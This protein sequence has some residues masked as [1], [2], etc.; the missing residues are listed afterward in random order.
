VVSTIVRYIHSVRSTCEI[1]LSVSVSFSFHHRLS[2]YVYYCGILVVLTDIAGKAVYLSTIINP[3]WGCL[4]VDFLLLFLI[5]VT[6]KDSLFILFH[7]LLT[8]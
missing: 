8:F 1:A 7:Y 6:H 5:V 2:M 4:C 3:A